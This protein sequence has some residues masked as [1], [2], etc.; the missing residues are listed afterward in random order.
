MKSIEIVDL[1]S[2]DD[3][4]N[5]YSTKQG[6]Q[7]V[8]N[9][10]NTAVLFQRAPLFSRVRVP[11]K[12]MIF[13]IFQGHESGVVYRDKEMFQASYWQKIKEPSQAM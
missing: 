4:S 2:D 3:F 7:I 11:F 10:E 1:S 9:H 5:D 8:L 13:K 12:E 6:K